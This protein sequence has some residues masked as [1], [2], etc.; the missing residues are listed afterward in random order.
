MLQLPNNCTCSNP[1][2]YPSNWKTGGPSLLK[3]DWYIQYYFRDPA[4]AHRY[5]YGKQVRIKCMNGFTDLAQRREAT[6]AILADEIHKLMDQGYNPITGSFIAP[7]EVNAVVNEMTPFIKALEAIMDKIDVSQ[8]SKLCLKS[9]LKYVKSAVKT[10]SLDR[11]PIGEVRRKHIKIILDHL[12]NTKKKWSDNNFNHYRA[13]LGML[14]NELLQY[15]AVEF[16]PVK[17]I[18]KKSHL[19]KLRNPLSRDQR[20]AVDLHLKKKGLTTFRLYMRLFFHSGIRNT[21]M[22]QLKGSDI[23]LDT[24]KIRCV[25]KK[26]RQPKNVEKT[27]KNIAVRYWKLA[28]RNCGPD[29]YVFSEGLKPGKVPITRPQI[30]RRWEVHVKA[31]KA[32]GGLGIKEDFYSLKHSNTTEVVDFAGEQEAAAFNSHSSTA[33]VIKIYDTKNNQRQHEKLKAVNNEF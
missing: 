28:L 4:F 32:K 18:R 31:P 29:D 2:V 13:H 24:Q 14:F 19:P 16:N 27:I 15:D 33:M 21:E 9:V 6:R 25:V 26:G 8:K 7:V 12:S 10:L 20:R 3:K 17:D 30:T 11:M 1:S 5:K 22:L 23:N